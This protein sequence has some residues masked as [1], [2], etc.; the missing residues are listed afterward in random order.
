MLSLVWFAYKDLSRHL[1]GPGTGT[2]PQ[3]GPGSR[4]LRMGLSLG[5][6]GS[7][8]CDSKPKPS[9]SP[10]LSPS[11]GP[12]PRAFES[13]QNFDEFMAVFPDEDRESYPDMFKL[14]EGCYEVCLYCREQSCSAFG[15]LALRRPLQIVHQAAPSSG[16]PP[17][18]SWLG[19]AG[20]PCRTCLRHRCRCPSRS[21]SPSRRCNLVRAWWSTTW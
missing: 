21:A 6:T 5:Y 2:G 13:C 12:S 16:Q 15:R 7:S 10:I 11:L 17:P 9:P 14:P 18:I 4:S 8:A 20:R 1:P 19:R 3:P